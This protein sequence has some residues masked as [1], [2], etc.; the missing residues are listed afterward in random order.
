[1]GSHNDLEKNDG[2]SRQSTGTEGPSTL[3]H[4]TP[5]GEEMFQQVI[6]SKGG[7][8]KWRNLGALANTGGL[9][10]DDHSPLGGINVS[11]RS[12][13]SRVQAHGEALKVESRSGRSVARGASKRPLSEVQA[14]HEEQYSNSA[15]Q[16]GRSEV[17]SSITDES[18]EEAREAALASLRSRLSNMPL[19]RKGVALLHYDDILEMLEAHGIDVATLD[20]DT[21]NLVQTIVNEA[22]QEIVLDV[23]S[24]KKQR[25]AA[26]KHL[27]ISAPDVQTAVSSLAEGSKTRHPSTS[28]FY[29]YVNS[30]SE[31]LGRLDPDSTEVRDSI[32]ARRENPVGRN[33]KKRKSSGGPVSTINPAP[34]SAPSHGVSSLS[35]NGAAATGN[36]NNNTQAPYQDAQMLISFSKTAF[37]QPN[38]S[39][40]ADLGMNFIHNSF[41]SRHNSV[42]PAFEAPFR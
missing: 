20:P 33:K 21:V 28:R 41:I 25:I 26:S 15:S 17:A 4:F 32:V 3:L 6:Q 35:V 19:Q 29:T 9:K 40:S 34:S 38:S 1:M 39:T 27:S 12:G 31:V 8:S 5:K 11:H 42:N 22:A 7:S 10:H 2:H 30:C 14:S 24:Q 18:A 23:C 13:K 36:T 16:G 37:A